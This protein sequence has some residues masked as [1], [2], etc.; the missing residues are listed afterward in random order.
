M[1]VKDHVKLFWQLSEK[2]KRKNITYRNFEKHTF[3]WFAIFLGSQNILPCS[4]DSSRSKSLKLYSRKLEI[5]TDHIFNQTDYPENIWNCFTGAHWS[6]E[7]YFLSEIGQSDSDSSVLKQ[8]ETSFY[9]Q[10]YQIGAIKT[11]NPC[12]ER[13]KNLSDCYRRHQLV[14]EAS[15]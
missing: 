5:K 11:S 1:Q 2:W 14:P 13:V 6:I 8:E 10:L 9:L 7:V 12:Y 15:C 3:Y 4:V